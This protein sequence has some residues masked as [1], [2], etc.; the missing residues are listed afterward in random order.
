LVAITVLDITALPV[1]LYQG[2]AIIRGCL[3]PIA[4]MQISKFLNGPLLNLR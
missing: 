3:A 1:F 2:T 4:Q